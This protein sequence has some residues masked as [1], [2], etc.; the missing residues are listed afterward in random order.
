MTSAFGPGPIV[1]GPIAG[2]LARL[3]LA[4]AQIV[5]QSGGE[6]LCALLG[7]FCHG[8]GLERLVTT[9]QRRDGADFG[10]VSGA[11][12]GTMR[13]IVPDERRRN[14]PKAARREAVVLRS[15]LEGVTT[16]ARATSPRCPPFLPS[17]LLRTIPALSC[18]HKPL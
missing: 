2:Q 14:G 6:P 15:A 7:F 13:C 12:R 10:P 5:P 9:W 8:A 11:R 16:L 1:G 17:A 18:D 4:A 3:R